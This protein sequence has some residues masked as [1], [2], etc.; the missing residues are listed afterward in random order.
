MKVFYILG[1]SV[2]LASTAVAVENGVGEA[3][4]A[5]LQKTSSKRDGKSLAH[6]REALAKVGAIDESQSL[7][8]HAKDANM[9]LSKLGFQNGRPPAN[10]D[11]PVGS[12]LVIKA[13]KGCANPRTGHVMVKC[14]EDELVSP[15]QK[16]QSLEKFMSEKSSC[17]KGIMSH[18]QWEK[19]MNGEKFC[20]DLKANASNM[21][22]GRSLAAVRESLNKLG[23]AKG[24]L[25]SSANDSVPAF[26]KQGFV[27]LGAPQELPVGTLFVIDA[28]EGCSV[29]KRS[30]HIVVKCGED[31][32]Y[33]DGRMQ[34][35]SEFESKQGHCVKA[36]M[37]KPEW[38]KALE[39]V[40]IQKAELSETT[41]AVD[42][43]G[44]H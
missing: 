4:C 11:I 38:G 29:N 23:F 28:K 27:N 44:V 30:G 35:L 15:G 31:A 18:P 10:K 3:L 33:S 13:E 14:G 40:K 9:A 24:G 22:G 1:L 32:I 42:E 2:C 20:R 36:A 43:D 17:L 37:F 8:T 12:I 6:V 25:G 39:G 21:K 26:E 5:E 7:G 16:S 41:E 19:S 34:S